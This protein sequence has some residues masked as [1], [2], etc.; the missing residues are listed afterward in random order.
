MYFLKVYADKNQKNIHAFSEEAMQA[1]MSYD[2]SGNVRELE[3]A[4]ERAV[5]F[6]NTETV[7]LSVLP[8]F[9]P[10]FAEARHSLK[11]KIGMPLQEL[12]SQAIKITLAHTRGDKAVAARL[13]GVSPRTI[14]RHLNEKES[15][16]TA[17]SLPE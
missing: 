14:Y 3:N 16:P 7:P 9:L 17:E 1:L 13:L 15:E 6:T 4:V 12:E 11:F 8:H 2:W 5:V 10:H